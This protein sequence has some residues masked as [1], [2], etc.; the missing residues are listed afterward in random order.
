MT[1]PRYSSSSTKERKR[2]KSSYFTKVLR[3][4][5]DLKAM[6]GYVSLPYEIRSGKV[7]VTFLGIAK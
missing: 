5:P 7:K 1:W 4:G 6:K 3:P 2:T